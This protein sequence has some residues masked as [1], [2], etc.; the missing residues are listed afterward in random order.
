MSYFP[1]STCICQSGRGAGYGLGRRL[2]RVTTP[3]PSHRNLHKPSGY[4]F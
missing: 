4:R 3:K 2:L 1:P